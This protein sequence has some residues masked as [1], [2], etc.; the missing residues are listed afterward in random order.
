MGKS[1]INW[2]GIYYIF[3]AAHVLVGLINDYSFRLWLM[4]FL[5]VT[6]SF[7]IIMVVDRDISNKE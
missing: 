1:G 4:R 7:A 2:R 6:I 5:I 3:T